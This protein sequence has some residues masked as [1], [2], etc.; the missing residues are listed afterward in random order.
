MRKSDG[1]QNSLV[2][3]TAALP[4]VVSLRQAPE[5]MSNLSRVQWVAG[6]VDHACSEH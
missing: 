3:S 2:F 4:R 5:K 6:L 1:L